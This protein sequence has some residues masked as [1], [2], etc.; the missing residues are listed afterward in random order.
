MKAILLAILALTATP[1]AA[2]PG[3]R[4]AFT[5]GAI[6]ADASW[7]RGPH[8]PAESELRVD[9]K[10]G[11]TLAPAE[12]GR[13]RVWLWMPDMGHGS[14]PTKLQPLL[15]DQGQPV[16]GAFRVTHV[17]FTMGGRWE[18]RV[19]LKLEGGGEETRSFPVTIDG[20][21]GHH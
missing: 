2:A 1:A 5:N 21:H 3:A 14:S 20:G 4:L 10:D 16:P 17:Y 9:W 18:V 11:A 15:D 13:F 8:S 12:P 19:S 6:L 7:V